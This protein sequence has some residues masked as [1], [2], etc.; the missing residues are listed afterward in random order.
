[1]KWY[2]PPFFKIYTVAGFSVLYLSVLT[3][4]YDGTIYDVFTLP[5]AGVFL[6]VNL[7]FFSL[8]AFILSLFGGITGFVAA[9]LLAK[10]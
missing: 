1:V 2:Y 5:F 4:I 3:D 10:Y 7:L 9:I 8:D 6:L